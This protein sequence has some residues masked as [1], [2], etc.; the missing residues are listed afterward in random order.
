[1]RGITARTQARLPMVALAT[2]MASQTRLN[3]ARAAD[4]RAGEQ[5]RFALQNYARCV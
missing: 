4:K 2:D 1:V 3:V 5:S